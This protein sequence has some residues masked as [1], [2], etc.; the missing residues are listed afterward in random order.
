MYHFF[1]VGCFKRLEIWERTPLS[2]C[3]D[4]KTG[5]YFIYV[6]LL[7][8]LYYQIISFDWPGQKQ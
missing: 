7:F 2:A 5:L 8:V 4:L 6:T 1:Y 3:G